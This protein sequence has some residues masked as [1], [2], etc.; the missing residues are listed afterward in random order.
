MKCLSCQ[1]TIRSEKEK[2][3]KTHPERAIELT[4]NLV[5]CILITK[6]KDGVEALL[7]LSGLSMTRNSKSKG[8]WELKMG[9]T[10]PALK[11]VITQW[12]NN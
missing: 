7:L 4:L 5:L 10:A 11:E 12:G 9:N 2:L 3:I 8:S 6:R 1:N